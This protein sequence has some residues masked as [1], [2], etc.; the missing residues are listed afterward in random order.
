SNNELSFSAALFTV[1]LC[2]IFGANYVAVKIGLAGMGVF[3][4]A[5]LRFTIAASAIALWAKLTGRSFLLKKGQAHQISI[6]TIIFTVQLSLFYF[7]IS[8]TS[9]THATLISNFLPFFILFLAHFFIP[10]DRITLRKTIGI[11]LGFSGIVLIFL[12]KE[13]GASE[14]KTGDIIILT[15]SFIW[16]CNTVYVKRIINDFHSFHLVLYPIVFSV[17]FLFIEAFLWDEKMLFNLNFMI[18]A[19][20]FYQSVITASFGF[21]AW[22]N[23]LKNYGATALHS[24][25]FIIPIS[26]VFFGGL[27]LYEPI[28][29]QI[30]SALILIASGILVVQLKPAVTPVFPLGRGL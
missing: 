9:A 6:L 11:L 4:S 10:G 24:F 18:L 5:A 2:I 17:P 21:V 8:R 26:G 12:E 23:L 25:I 27:L 7:G 19:S 22:N 14:F 20:L 16:A 30:I 13:Q 3:T 15:V 29:Y 28:T 1:F